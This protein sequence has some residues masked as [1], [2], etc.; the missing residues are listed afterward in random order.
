MDRRA[1]RATVHRVAKSWTRL[2]SNNNSPSGIIPQPVSVGR[3]AEIMETAA[4]VVLCVSCTQHTP[5]MI[6]GSGVPSSHTRAVGQ[7][8]FLLKRLT[9]VDA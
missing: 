5:M 3:R 9:Y 2:T 4:A 1:W 7:S 6:S 8:G